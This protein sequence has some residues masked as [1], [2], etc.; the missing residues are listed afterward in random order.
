MVEERDEVAV[1]CELQVFI[2]EI[3]YHAR[4]FEQLMVVV[5]RRGI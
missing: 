2:A 1:R 3:G 4:K 5:K